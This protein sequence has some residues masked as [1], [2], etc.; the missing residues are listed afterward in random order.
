MVVIFGCGFVTAPNTDK[1]DSD[2]RIDK[3]NHVKMP[4]SANQ[5]LLRTNHLFPLERTNLCVQAP[6]QYMEEDFAVLNATLL[7]NL[8]F[9]QNH[10]QSNSGHPLTWQ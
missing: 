10:Q 8:R 3:S 4:V 9:Q 5:I 2:A 7:T 1:N 6:T